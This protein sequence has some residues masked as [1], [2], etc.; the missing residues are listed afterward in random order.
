M[1]SCSLK[2]MVTPLTTRAYVTQL[3]IV[4]TTIMFGKQPGGTRGG[5]APKHAGK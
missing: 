4:K 1:N 5:K 3:V 2:E